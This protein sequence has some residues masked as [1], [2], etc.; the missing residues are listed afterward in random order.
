MNIDWNQ[1]LRLEVVQKF[2]DLKAQG[3]GA[4]CTFDEIAGR[5]RESLPA[6]SD[7]PRVRSSDQQKIDLEIL[8]ES[9]RQG[10]TTIFNVRAPSGVLIPDRDYSCIRLFPD[11]AVDPAT[12]EEFKVQEITHS[13]ISFV[14][15]DRG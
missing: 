5:V 14:V 3:V 6:L 8:K 7:D 2:Q 11:R 4:R 9:L 12:G 10:I 13:E 1:A 15:V